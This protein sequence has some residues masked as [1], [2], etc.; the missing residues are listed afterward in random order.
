MP[1]LEVCRRPTTFLNTSRTLLHAQRLAS[2]SVTCKPSTLRH[3]PRNPFASLNT[4]ATC[5]CANCDGAGLHR[6][7]IPPL[8]PP[9]YFRRSIP[10]IASSSYRTTVPLR[11]LSSPAQRSVAAMEPVS[12]EAIESYAR[13]APYN[14]GI[15]DF[16]D[17]GPILGRDY[18]YPYQPFGMIFKPPFSPMR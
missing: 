6:L 11:K 2:D 7:F 17:Y 13:T 18:Y 5:R 15:P 14:M 1:A 10:N 3:P 8:P 9:S 4:L 16:S 12:L